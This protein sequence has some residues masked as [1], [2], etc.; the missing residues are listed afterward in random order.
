MHKW[1]KLI[2]AYGLPGSGKST[3]LHILNSTLQHTNTKTLLIDH[4]EPRYEKL[5]KIMMN[6]VID[7]FNDYGIVILDYVWSHTEII[8]F[9]RTISKLITIDALTLYY[10]KPDIELS[11]SNDLARNREKSAEKTIRTLDVS[12]ISKNELQSITNI[13]KIILNYRPTYNPNNDKII[14]S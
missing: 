5:F 14:L 11:I 9:L 8:D 3:T 12:E 6:E 2:L 4:D 7:S 1:N 10:F 13:K